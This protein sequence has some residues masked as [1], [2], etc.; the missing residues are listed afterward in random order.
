MNNFM[1]VVSHQ[2]STYYGNFGLLWYNIIRLHEYELWSSLV[3]LAVGN[4]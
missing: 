1:V 3:V 4:L 2:P